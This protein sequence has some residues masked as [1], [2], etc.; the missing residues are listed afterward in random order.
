VHEPLNRS[1]RKVDVVELNWEALTGAEYSD[2][3]RL[4]PKKLRG[5]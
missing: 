2:A 4:T 5:W 3:I 1:R